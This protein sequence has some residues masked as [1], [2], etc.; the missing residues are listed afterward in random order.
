MVVDVIIVVIGCIG[1]LFLAGWLLLLWLFQEQ[2]SY[3]PKMTPEQ[4]EVSKAFIAEQLRKRQEAEEKARIEAQ[5]AARPAAEAAEVESD[6]D[7]KLD[8][9]EEQER[10]RQKRRERWQAELEKQRQAEAQ[11]QADLDELVSSFPT[12]LVILC[13]RRNLEKDEY[14]FTR[15][16]SWVR[17]V[18]EWADYQPERRVSVRGLFREFGSSDEAPFPGLTSHNFFVELLQVLEQDGKIEP[19]PTQTN[20]RR[21]VENWE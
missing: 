9:L 4:I 14:T 7:P 2:K 16:L 10:R 20:A 1:G 13:E 6:P 8:P 11:K 15:L 12:W 21:L 3:G 18:L 5:A 17:I 19:D